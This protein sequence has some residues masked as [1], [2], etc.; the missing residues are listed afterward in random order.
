MKFH[1][2]HIIPHPR[3]HGLNGYKEVID[4]IQ[5]GLSELGHETTYAVNNVAT[6]ATN[7]IFVA[8]MFPSE[9][10]QKLPSDT[11]IYQLE[12]LGGNL[13]PTYRQALK[14]FR[15]WDYSPSNIAVLAQIGGAHKPKLVPIAHAPVLER[16]AKPSVQ[17]IDV[18]IY[19]IAGQER[20]AA[21]YA[22]SQSGLT[23]VF[24]S[25]LYGAARDALIARSKL[26]VNVTLHKRVFEMV[27]VSYLLANK[28]AVVCVL[29]SNMPMEAGFEGSVKISNPE[30][31]VKDCD[32][33][34]KDDERRRAL[35]EAGYVLF[36]SR[37]IANVLAQALAA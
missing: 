21:V 24:V 3:M 26:I 25:G 6:G 28:K 8:Q 32:D 10:T 30:S 35:E 7:I 23:T 5:W 36:K 18:L 14:T 2:A 15:V 20:L 17:D 9:V 11:I 27:R 4:A 13:K 12:Q 29:A 34:I 1:L 22:L 33:L 31:L 37:N 16:I 19:G